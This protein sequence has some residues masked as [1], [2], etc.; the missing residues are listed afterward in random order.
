MAGLVIGD[1]RAFLWVEQAVLLLQAGDDPF[2]GV[3]EVAGHDHLA[4]C[5]HGQQ[6]R[7]VDDVGQVRSGEPG[8]ASSYLLQVHDRVELHA[9][10]VD[11]QNVQPP[12]EVG[13][14]DQDLAVEPSGPQERGVEDLGAIGRGEDD[15]AGSAV[16]PV[17]LDQEL[18]Q[19]LLAFV[20]PAERNGAALADG[21]QLVDEHEAR[22]LLAGLLEEVADPSCAD[23]DEHLHEVRPA[24]SE[25]RDLG[26]TG[27][28]PGQERLAGPRR[29]DEEDALGDP[30]ADGFV[31]LRVPE[32]VHHLDE[33]RLGL[34]NAGDVPERDA[35]VAFGDELRPVRAERHDARAGL[36]DPLAEVVPHQNHQQKRK[37]PGKESPHPGVVL[38]GLGVVL[39]TL[40][41]H[42]WDESGVGG[43]D[44]TVSPEWRGGGLVVEPGPLVPFKLSFLQGEARE[45]LVADLDT[46]DRAR[47]DL[48]LELAVIDGLDLRAQKPGVDHEEADEGE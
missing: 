33:L 13:P 5:T 29:T 16:E 46:R 10:R 8:R 48:G 12:L 2:D 36:A 9:V 44:R 42:E 43:P 39:E 45:V 7:F 30:A 34:V 19:R 11:A 23:A 3:V 20:V 24:D 27:D 35:G 41:V 28:G 21:V 26:L 47:L 22:C 31:L 14:V 25:E 6:R 1:G 15:D 17:H 32:E 40:L 38:R 4:T 18:V 37:Y